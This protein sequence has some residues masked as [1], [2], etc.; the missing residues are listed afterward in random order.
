L[1]W[2]QVVMADRA[3]AYREH[4]ELLEAYKLKKLSL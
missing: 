4:Q 1:K 2:L 3:Q